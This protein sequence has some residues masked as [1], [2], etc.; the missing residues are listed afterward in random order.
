MS[1]HLSLHCQLAVPRIISGAPDILGTIIR[2]YSSENP[3]TKRN[4]ANNLRDVVKQ[5]ILKRA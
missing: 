2:P 4:V 3:E 5:A 1:L